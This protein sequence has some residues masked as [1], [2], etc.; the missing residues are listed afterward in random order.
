MFWEPTVPLKLGKD[1]P[2][3]NHTPESVG[4]E[5]SGRGGKGVLW[6]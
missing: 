6:M 1:L 2:Q 5:F 4:T 3:N